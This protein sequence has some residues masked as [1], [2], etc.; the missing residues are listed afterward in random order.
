MSTKGGPVF[1][2]SLPGGQLAPCPS[3][4]YGTA[5]TPLWWHMNYFQMTRISINLLLL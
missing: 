2:L 3:V 4:S 5:F 1:T